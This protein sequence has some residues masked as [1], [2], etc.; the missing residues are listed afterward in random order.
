MP[1]TWIHDLS[2][3][4]EEE[5][6]SQLG[7]TIDGTLDELRK[8]VKERWTD[9]EPYLHSQSAAKSSLVTKP[10]Q[11]NVDPVVY[12]GNCLSKIKI[13]LA[14]DLISGIPVLS[15]T[16]PEILKF[17]IRAKQVFELKLISDP[18]LMTVLIKRTSGRITQILSAHLGMT[19]TLNRINKVFYWPDMR[20]EVR[21]FVRQCQDCQRAKPA[22]DSQVGLHSSEV[23]TRPMG[24]SLLIS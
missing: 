1:V 22:P 13:K 12:Q 15:G 5:L 6:A 14:T 10:V 21:A 2:K 4:H 8:R 17:L 9:M 23:V 18:E 7:L 11:Q 24:A 3:Q 20:R 19:K 16:D